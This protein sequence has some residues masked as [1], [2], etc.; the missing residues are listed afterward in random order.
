MRVKPRALVAVIKC[1]ISWEM[2]LIPESGFATQSPR[3]AQAMQSINNCF[4]QGIQTGLEEGRILTPSNLDYFGSMACLYLCPACSW[5]PPLLHSHG[6]LAN[7]RTCGDQQQGPASLGRGAKAPALF[8]RQISL[9]LWFNSTYLCVYIVRSRV[10]PPG[11]SNVKSQPL[12]SP[13]GVR[14]KPWTTAWVVLRVMGV[15]LPEL[16]LLKFLGAVYTTDFL[17]R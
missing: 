7:T 9:S 10:A 4:A 6:I 8:S 14:M 17:K 11:G 12:R 5:P 1:G 15:I 16:R 13:W 2:F 3:L